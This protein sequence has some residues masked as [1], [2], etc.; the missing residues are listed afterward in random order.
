MVQIPTGLET[1]V[2]RRSLETRSLHVRWSSLE[3]KSRE[4]RSLNARRFGFPF[5]AAGPQGWV[6]TAAGVDKHAAFHEDGATSRENEDA[7]G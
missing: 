3:G 6:G 4:A 2:H 1:L 7:R 5:P